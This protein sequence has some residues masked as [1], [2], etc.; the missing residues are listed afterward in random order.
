M[1]DKC[2]VELVVPMRREISG[3]QAMVDVNAQDL[4]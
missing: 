1:E 3:T 4:E 2:V